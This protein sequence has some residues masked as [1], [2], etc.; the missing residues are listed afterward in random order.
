MAVASIPGIELGAELGHGS[1]S[2]VLRGTREGRT[3]A[4]K[5]PLDAATG[6]ERELAYR[7]F[8]REAIAL[9]RARHASLPEVMEIGRAKG[10]PFLV[11]E[12]AA[13][14]HLP[15]AWNVA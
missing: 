6:P 3:Y 15:S 14:R 4:V 8:L 12:L 5:L 7:R 9:A 2:V 13:E 10:V 1:H 11:M